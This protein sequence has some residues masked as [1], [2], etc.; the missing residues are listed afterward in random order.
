MQDS[1]CPKGWGLPINGNAQT[2][3]SW[4]NLLFTNYSLHDANES[5]GI[6]AS[7][8]DAH[9]TPLSLVYSGYYFWVDGGLSSRGSYGRFWS[10][11]SASTANAHHLHF[12]STRLQPQ[13]SGS[14]LVGFTI[15]CAVHRFARGDSSPQKKCPEE[16]L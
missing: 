16:H 10:S 5:A 2:T 6:Q 9:K 7:S 13:S 1:I 8:L 14:K 4:I 12:Y 3:K 15:R 11:T